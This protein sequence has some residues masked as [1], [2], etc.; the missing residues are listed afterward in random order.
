M[1]LIHIAET[2]DVFSYHG[3]IP[4]DKAVKK[5]IEIKKCFVSL[6]TRHDAKSD[7]LCVKTCI[8]NPEL[9]FK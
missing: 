6:K 9:P 4:E 7:K 1:R 8:H 2:S 3:I 5:L